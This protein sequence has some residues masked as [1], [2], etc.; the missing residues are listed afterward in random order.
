M[1]KYRKE[2]RIQDTEIQER[3]QSEFLWLRFNDAGVGQRQKPSWL[4]KQVSFFAAV[5]LRCCD[6]A[7]L[8][9]SPRSFE[10]GLWSNFKADE[11]HKGLFFSDL[12]TMEDDTTMRSRN[13]ENYFASEP[14]SDPERTDTWFSHL[15]RV[16]GWR[17]CGP[18]PPPPPRSSS[19]V[20]VC[21][22]GRLLRDLRFSQQ[23]CWR[24]KSSG[25]WSCIF[26]LVIPDVLRDRCVSIFRS[27]SP[28]IVF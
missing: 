22:H 20:L 2:Y 15:Y 24:F 3:I 27:T 16:P 1:S 19:V 4:F 11:V 25:M 23:F 14:V 9:F 18:V 28:R 17:I 26:W 12:M 13:S 8:G 7:S 6:A 5:W 10:T 21:G